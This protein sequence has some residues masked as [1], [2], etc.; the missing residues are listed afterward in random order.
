MVHTC[1]DRGM[2]KENVAFIT[3]EYYSA[4]KKDAFES[5]IGKLN[6]GVVSLV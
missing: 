2:G 5:Q 6:Y 1:I 3:P 4:I